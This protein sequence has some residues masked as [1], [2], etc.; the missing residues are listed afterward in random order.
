MARAQGGDTANRHRRSAL[1]E[2]ASLDTA[3]AI[4]VV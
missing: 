2:S 1:K 3:M 4:I